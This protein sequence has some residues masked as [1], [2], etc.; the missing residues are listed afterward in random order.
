MDMK[1]I[2]QNLDDAVSGKKSTTGE[3]DVNNMKAILESFDNVDALLDPTPADVKRIDEMASMNISMSGETADEVARLVSIIKGSGAD[4]KPV[5]TD[6]I[7]PPMDKLRAIVGPKEPDDMDDL[8]PGV[9][10]EPCPICGKVHLGNSSSCSGSADEEVEEWDNSPEE[11]YKD[12]QYMTKDLSG[13]INREKKS[14]AKA[15]DG[16]NAMAVEELKSELRN[17]LMAK[18]KGE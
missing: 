9:Q 8:K 4:A 5:D 13:G 7:N 18:M 6:M 11:E 16:D 1:K 15:Q 10:K 2:L 14:Y 17:A 3:A 12:H